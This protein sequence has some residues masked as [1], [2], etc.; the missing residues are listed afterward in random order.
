VSFVFI[1][2]LSL[3]NCI[4]CKYFLPICGLYFCFVY[5]FLCYAR[6]FKFNYVPLFIFV[7]FIALGVGSKKD[8]AAIYVKKS[9]AMFSS[10]SFIVSGFTL[11][12]QSTL[13]FFVC[14]W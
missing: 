3:V 10:K 14:V 1:Q 5:D 11:D 8:L 7:I 13:S 6:A 2:I 12:L 9:S 4:I